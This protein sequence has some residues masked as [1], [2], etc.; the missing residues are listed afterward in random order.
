MMTSEQLSDLIGEHFETLRG[1]LLR[2]VGTN[3]DQMEQRVRSEM[4]DKLFA[5]RAPD[6]K[7]TPMG[8]LYCDGKMIGDVRPVFKKI[9]AEVLA[10]RDKG[11]GK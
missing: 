1:D 9:V 10:E 6:F 2:L 4:L 7:L 5:L 3:A 11:A 8:E